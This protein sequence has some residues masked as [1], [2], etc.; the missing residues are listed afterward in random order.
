MVT[1][2]LT[3]IPPRATTYTWRRMKSVSDAAVCSNMNLLCAV[4]TSSLPLWSFTD[5]WPFL[6]VPACCDEAGLKLLFVL[7]TQIFQYRCCWYHQRRRLHLNTVDPAGSEKIKERR[8]LESV[9]LEIKDFESFMCCL[10]FSG[11]FYISE[12]SVLCFYCM[13]VCVTC[14]RYMKC[15]CLHVHNSLWLSLHRSCVK[16]KACLWIWQKMI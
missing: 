14:R 7:V 12:E 8:I 10:W 1:G 13:C 6:L 11:L 16:I 5:L 4:L 9:L 3:N 2:C 15:V